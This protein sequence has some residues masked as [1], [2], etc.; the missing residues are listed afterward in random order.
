MISVDQ[1]L[2]M[3]SMMSYYDSSVDFSN[4]MTSL[5]EMTDPRRQPHLKFRGFHSSLK[6]PEM[7]FFFRLQSFQDLLPEPNRSWFS[8]APSLCILSYESLQPQDHFG[9][10]ALHLTGPHSQSHPA[11]HGH[12][13]SLWEDV[14]HWEL[15]YVCA[16]VCVCERE[17]ER[18]STR[19]LL[20]PLHTLPKATTKPWVTWNDAAR[21]S[22]ALGP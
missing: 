15:A 20:I 9:N 1:E 10:W 6:G 5:L 4:K 7:W 14:N 22:Y 12:Q 18:D 21:W 19:D 16:C 17:R 11:F 13:L 8:L 3:H 2:Q